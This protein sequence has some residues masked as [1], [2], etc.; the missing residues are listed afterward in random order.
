MSDFI[1]GG[2]EDFRVDQAQ[3]AFILAQQKRV[4]FAPNQLAFKMDIDRTGMM[5]GEQPEPITF[6]MSRKK[7]SRSTSRKRSSSAKKRTPA[8]VVAAKKVTA[9]KRSAPPVK[10]AGGWNDNTVAGKYFDINV[11]MREK[12]LA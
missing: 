5:V 3:A 11:D 8:V 6:D 4:S 12:R 1:D 9:A 10:K 2:E 7:K